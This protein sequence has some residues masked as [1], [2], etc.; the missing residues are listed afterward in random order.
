MTL[1]EGMTNPYRAPESQDAPP[2]PVFGSRL[3]AAR[4]GMRQGALLGAK[5][6]TCIMLG[7]AALMWIAV[8]GGIAYRHFRD[9]IP[10]SYLVDILQP[11]EGLIST[12]GAVVAAVLV[13]TVAGAVVGALGGTISYRKV[14]HRSNNIDK[15][16]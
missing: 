13:A 11:L 2:P 3:R 12:A 16:A 15:S 10:L 7:L 8:L 14:V 6:M 4:A 9:G 1:H 5:W